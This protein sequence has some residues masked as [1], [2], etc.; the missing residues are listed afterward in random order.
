MIYDNY[1]ANVI[2]VTNYDG[3]LLVYFIKYV[4]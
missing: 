4:M 2:K 3:F 1:H